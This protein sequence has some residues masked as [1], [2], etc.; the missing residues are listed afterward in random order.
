MINVLTLGCFDLLHK[1]HILH[2]IKARF[3]ISK[4]LSIQDNQIY[5]IAAYVSQE[6]IKKIKPKDFYYTNEEKRK[7]EL[8]STGLVQK[9]IIQG[10]PLTIPL[11][12]KKL[13]EK[14]IQINYLVLGYDQSLRF[15]FID[16]CRKIKND[17]ELSKTNIF[18]LDNREFD[19]ISDYKP[20]TTLIYR[21]LNGIKDAKTIKKI[22]KYV[23]KKC[24]TSLKNSYMLT[25]FFSAN[26]F[27]QKKR[28]ISIFED[29]FFLCVHSNSSFNY[30]LNR[31]NLHNSK[32]FI[33][34]N[35]H[36]FKRSKSI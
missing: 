14:K 18:I 19:F 7:R 3:E 22:R 12:L 23:N 16:L 15:S 2:L 32:N 5:L 29:R 13:K 11:I 6:R 24:L 33:E 27:K 36:S 4:K 9:T 25:E 21:E 8:E 1:G 17:I 28:I 10:G 34:Y 20:S 30:I 26:N 35:N 31:Y